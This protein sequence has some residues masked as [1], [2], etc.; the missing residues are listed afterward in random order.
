ML[1]IVCQ[2]LSLLLVQLLPNDLNQWIQFKNSYY[3][4]HVSLSL[5][6]LS[7]PWNKTQ[8]CFNTKTN[9]N[10]QMFLYKVSLPL[11]S[12]EQWTKWACSDACN[13][14]G[15]QRPQ[16]D[17]TVWCC[18]AEVGSFSLSLDFLSAADIQSVDI[19]LE[20]WLCIDFFSI[21]LNTFYGL[22]EVLIK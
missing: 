15:E 19:P 9:L 12:G 11:Y 2:T 3:I 4:K 10:T 17:E 6:S 5:F 18:R 8:R 22:F 14:V 7:T 13:W 16:K 21:L 20:R 1:N